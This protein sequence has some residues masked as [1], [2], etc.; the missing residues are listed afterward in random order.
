MKNKKILIAG[1]EGMVGKAI[2]DLFKS[3]NLNVIDCNRK[4]LDLTSQSQVNS[5]FKKF[6]P[7]IVVNAA[8]RVG[9]IL[10]N[11]LY[12]TDYI[13][14]N[15]MIGFNLLNASLSFNV[16]KFINLGSACIYSKENRQPIKEEYLL[17]SILEESNE[18][19]AIAKIATL[20]YCEY[21]KKFLKK[22]F[23]S[24]QPTN[25]YGERDNFNLRSS[26]VIPA[27]VRKF[28]ESK[29]NKK[30]FVEVWG[31]GVAK[32]EFM[33]V[34]DLADA[35]YFCLDKN[36]SYSF[37]NVASGDYISIKT[38]SKL[39]KKIVGYEGKIFFNKKYPDGVLERR[40]DI[41]KIK[42]L[43]WHSK[44]PLEKGLKEYYEYFK[45][46]NLS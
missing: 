26:H 35:V 38:L 15:T 7:N 17:T 13:Y 10:D 29:V 28:H 2:F 33:H 4:D 42:K 37:I 41:S 18:G 31:T 14:I 5:W 46:L 12:K 44:I 20:K 36:M 21:I 11:S 34:K 19:Y 40:L 23:I 45:K 1:Q 27:L 43:G 24:L 30:N 32:R 9:G 22:D 3:K 6:R 8:G 25:L 39:I 16:K